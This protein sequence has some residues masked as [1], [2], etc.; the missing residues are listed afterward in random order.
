MVVQGTAD[1]D[2]EV[3]RNL[4]GYLADKLAAL[5]GR[6]IGAVDQKDFRFQCRFDSSPFSFLSFLSL[7]RMIQ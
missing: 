4:L 1:L 3:T 5:S 7:L 6:Q 2:S